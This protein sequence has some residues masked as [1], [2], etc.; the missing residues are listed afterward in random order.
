VLKQYLKQISA[1]TA[2]DRYPMVILD[3][4]GWHTQDVAAEFDHL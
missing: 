2:N 1:F 4:A 3:G